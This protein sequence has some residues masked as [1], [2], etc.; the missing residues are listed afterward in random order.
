MDEL[1]DVIEGSR[2]YVSCIY[3]VN[4]IDQITIEELNVLDKLPHYCPICAYHGAERWWGCAN[5]GS[6]AAASRCAAVALARPAPLTRPPAR[7]LPRVE[8]G[9]AGGDDVG[10][11]WA[12]AH[13][14]QA[15]SVCAMSWWRAEGWAG[16]D[17]LLACTPACR[18]RCT[19][20][21]SA[22]PCTA[23]LSPQGKLPDWLDPV[24]LPAERC[25][26]E[27]FCNRLHKTL[28]KQFKYALVWGSSVKHRPQKVGKDHVLQD[29]DIVQIVKKI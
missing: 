25:T 20:A 19:H 9:W 28:I 14:H 27:F 3:V 18:W 24:V 5:W 29:E 4:K 2:V 12:A 11:P 23:C 21:Y 7:P 13:L 1:I 22:T 15:K 8:L 26:I 10:V 6:H 16:G 17:A